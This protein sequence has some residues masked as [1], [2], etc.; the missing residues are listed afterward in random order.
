MSDNQKEEEYRFVMPTLKDVFMSGDIISNTLIRDFNRHRSFPHERVLELFHTDMEMKKHMSTRAVLQKE[1]DDA[2]AEIYFH[3]E[4]VAELQEERSKIDKV[5]SEA[6]DE[7]NK[8]YDLEKDTKKRK[9]IKKKIGA[10]TSSHT[11]KANNYIADFKKLDSKFIHLDD[12]TVSCS[13]GIKNLSLAISARANRDMEFLNIRQ[14]AEDFYLEHFYEFFDLVFKSL[15][16]E[17][18]S[19]QWGDDHM[20]DIVNHFFDKCKENGIEFR[21]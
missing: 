6:V 14:K 7:L 13:E 15:E 1:Y 12:L 17:S 5:Y 21:L 2:M 19:L 8:A 20:S 4:D 3:K 10:E 11:M 18:E 9:L 16:D